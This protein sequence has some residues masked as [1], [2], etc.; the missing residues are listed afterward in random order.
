MSEQQLYDCVVGSKSKPGLARV[1]GFRIA[2]FRPAMT[3]RGMRTP[4][5]ADGAG[6]PDLVMTK[7]SR[8]LVVELKADNA[9]RVPVEQIA[10]LQAFRDAGAEAWIWRPSH[11]HDGT[12]ERE[13]RK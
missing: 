9:A 10:W 1:Y 8:L 3:S 12:I 4:V 11:W 5:S 7:G 13:L 6:F 2:H